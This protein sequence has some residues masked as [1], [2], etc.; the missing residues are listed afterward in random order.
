MQNYN[1]DKEIT[2]RQTE[3]PRAGKVKTSVYLLN[4]WAKESHSKEI[5][6]RIKCSKGGYFRE[7][8]KDI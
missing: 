5:Q 7:T 6:K 8:L 1:Y 2:S 3:N 4:G